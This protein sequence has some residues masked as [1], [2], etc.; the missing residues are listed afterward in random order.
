MRRLAT[1]NEAYLRSLR[2]AGP[3]AAALRLSAE[4]EECVLSASSVTGVT[5]T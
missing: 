4:V 2:P 5:A 3:V 1:E